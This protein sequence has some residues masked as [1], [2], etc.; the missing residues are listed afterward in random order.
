MALRNLLFLF[1]DEQ[2][3]DTLGAYGNRKIHTP[4]LDE[5]A[6]QSLVFQKCYVTQPVCTPSRSSILTGLYPHT[7]GCTANNVPLLETTLCVPQLLTGYR[8]AYFG[9]WHLGDEVFA[10][11][12]FHDWFSIEDMYVRYYRK[13]RDRNV[14][15]T[16]HH[17]LIAN[18]YAPDRPGYGGAG[19]FSR[20]AAVRLPEV[21]CKP[22]YLA[23]E[24]S[25]W[26]AAQPG[27]AFRGIRQ[28]SR[29]AHAVLWAS[30]QSVRS[31]NR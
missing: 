27:G 13:G 28:F 31:R 30:Q 23:G 12:G 7:N 4:Y 16:Y 3:A 29:A 5:L 22:A 21:H 24:F 8:T 19:V 17:W 14:R 26:I 25:R 1:T 11:H 10:Q 18:G 2:R 6:A 20:G 15:S 9:K